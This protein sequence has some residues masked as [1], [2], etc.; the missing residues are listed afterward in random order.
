MTIL[1]PILV[2]ASFLLPTAATAAPVT[3]F[4]S[5]NEFVFLD[6]GFADFVDSDTDGDGITISASGGTDLDGTTFAELFVSSD[7]SDDPL[8]ESF[9]LLDVTFDFVEGGEDTLTAIYGDLS[10]TAADLFGPTATAIFSFF[11]EDAEDGFFTASARIVADEVNV[12]PVPASL[13]LLLVGVAGLAALR[14]RT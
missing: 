11:E 12:I 10:G 7:E 3:I 8:L 14:R 9:T 6:G 13:P 1:K 5:L 2:A 4:E